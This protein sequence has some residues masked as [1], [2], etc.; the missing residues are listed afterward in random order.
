MDGSSAAE[1]FFWIDAMKRVFE[2]GTV[3]LLS[4]PVSKLAVHGRFLLTRD[5]SGASEGP[6]LAKSLIAMG[7]A[8]AKLYELSVRLKAI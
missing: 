6:A 4:D 1:L 2:S 3:P 8:D 7:D 5:S